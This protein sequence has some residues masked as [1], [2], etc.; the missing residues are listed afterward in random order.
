MIVVRDA[1]VDLE[2]EVPAGE[3][4]RLLE[5]LHHLVDPAPISRERVPAGEC[6]TTS[7]VKYSFRSASMSPRW[8]AA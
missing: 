7:S 3:L 8:N 2:R 4:E 5:A 6:Q 1:V